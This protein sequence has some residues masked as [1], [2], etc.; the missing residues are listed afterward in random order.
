MIYQKKY[1]YQFQF[2]QNLALFFG[3]FEIGVSCHLPAAI[4]KFLPFFSLI[5]SIINIFFYDWCW[6]ID[7]SFWVFFLC[8]FW[9][10]S[11][12]FSIFG[13]FQRWFLLCFGSLNDYSYFFA[14]FYVFLNVNFCACVC[15]CEGIS[16]LFYERLLSWRFIFGA[17]TPVCGSI[18]LRLAFGAISGR[19]ATLT[20]LYWVS[21]C[22]ISVINASFDSINEILA[23]AGP[24]AR[25]YSIH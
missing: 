18:L 23:A 12:H 25:K 13:E 20:R 7:N 9:G 6:I 14:I 8:G 1:F 21:S 24:P 16:V 4:G 2:I 10:F 5:I 19:R 11:R 22:P 15:V 17:L 3:R